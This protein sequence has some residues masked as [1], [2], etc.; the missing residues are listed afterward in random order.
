MSESQ[1]VLN[2]GFA[3]K[4]RRPLAPR[5][6]PLRPPAFVPAPFGPGHAAAA[7]VAGA[8][9]AARLWEAQVKA[10]VT[11]SSDPRGLSPLTSNDRE[12]PKSVDLGNV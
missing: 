5:A 4:M 8:H 11:V 10:Q 3:E 1:S 2:A 12:I 7:T 9:E 6:R